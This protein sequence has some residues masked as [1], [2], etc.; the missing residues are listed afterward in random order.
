MS[1]NENEKESEWRMESE[2]FPG[3][4]VLVVDKAQDMARKGVA[5]GEWRLRLLESQKSRKQ[6][7]YG[8]YQ[9]LSL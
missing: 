4:A 9:R 8:Q 1:R 5:K 6:H 2:D 3:G 7:R